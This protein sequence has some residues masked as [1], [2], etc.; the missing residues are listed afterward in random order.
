MS[1]AQPGSTPQNHN[2]ALSVLT[3]LFFMWGFITCLN[4]I[5]VPHLKAVFDLNYFQAMLI[6]FCFFTAYAVMSIPFGKLVG[7]LGYKQGV[8]TGL[9]IAAVGCLL[10]YPAAGAHSYPLFLGALF[11]L[12]SG[13]TLLQVSANPYVTLLSPAG[14]EARTL[15]LV[16]G[17]NSLGTTVAPYIGALFILGGTVLT[18]EQIAAMNAAEREAYQAGQAAS[19]QGPYLVLAGIL[20]ALAVIFFLIRLPKAEDI[21]E[22]VSAHA[23]DNKTSV[24]QYRHL[25]LA[26]VGLFCYVG[27]EVAIGSLIVNV[28][29]LPEVAG[30]PE[31]KAAEYLT[32]YWG[33]AMI[34]RFIGSAVLSKFDAGKCLAVNATINVGLIAIAILFGGHVAMYALLSIGFF[35]SIMFPTI[36]SLGARGL[37]KFTSAGAG[38]LATAIVGGA[39]VPVF[40]GWAADAYGLMPSFVISAVCYVY[41]IYFG[42]SG[43]KADD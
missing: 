41:I 15:T 1:S 3:S 13:I 33:G 19:V 39:I 25:L 35:N 29:A 30:L 18:A 4:D 14:K 2:G 26:A 22:D 20:L 6:Q 34:G 38:I 36:F 23:H 28:L 7:K 8:V 31:H 37:G 16:Q 17:F 10:F 9:V 40:Q 5:L 27:A 42:L 21:A 24:W 43:H 32:W 12:A 11:V